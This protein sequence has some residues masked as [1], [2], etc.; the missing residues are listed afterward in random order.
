MAV[1][2]S[3]HVVVR[4]I[5]TGFDG[6]IKKAFK[7]FASQALDARKT[8][9]SLVRTGYTLGPLISQLVS[10]IGALAGGLVSLGAAA[11][12]AVPSLVSLLGVF[13]SLGLAAVVTMSAF[14]GVGA[15]IS[16]GLKASKKAATE[17]A[18]SK[19]AAARRI[20]DAEKRLA[21]VLESNTEDLLEADLRLTEAQK[22]LNKALEDGREEIQQLGFE[23]EDAALGEKKAALE[24]EKARETLAR[25][26]DLPPNSR[27]RREAQL[28][29]AEAELNLRKAKDRNADL[30]KE[31]DRLAGD[32]KKTDRYV[33]ALQAEQDALDNQTKTQRDALR[34][35]EEAEE[36]LRRAREDA[37]R[38]SGSGGLD[39][40]QEALDNL[41]PAARKFVDFIVNEFAPAL[42][43]LRDFAAAGLFPELETQLRRL[44]DELFPVLEPLFFNLAQSVGKAIKSI[45]DSILDP[46]NISDLQA[47]FDQAGY[48]VEGFGKVA[49]NVYDAFL[50][51]LVGADSQTRRFVDFLVKKTGEFA[52]F[53]D[54]K[55]ASG[56]LDAFFK[57]TGDIA[58]QW[59]A[60][61]GNTFSGIV[62]IVRANFTPGGGGYILLDWFEEATAK[63]EEF[64]GSVEGQAKLSEY[65][66]AVAIRAI[67]SSLGAFI[68]EILK[69][70]ADPNV[71]IFWDTI[72][73]AAPSFG[74]LLTQLNGAGPA[75]ANF[76]V[77]LLKFMEVTLSTGA[78]QIFWNTLNAALST[79]TNVL[80][81]PAIKKLFDAGAKIL[82]FF[83]AL[84]LI[85]GAVKFA[86]FVFGGAILQVMA[87]F[88]KLKTAILLV[89]GTF[90]ALTIIFNVGLAPLIAIAAA[91]AAVVA[92]I[93]T[94]Y[95]QSEL[96]REAVAKLI[97][98]VG[99]ALREAFETIK[100][101][102]Q[103]F[104]PEIEA[105]KGVFEKIGDFI[106]KYIV[107]LFQFVL[108]AA[109]KV[110]AE[111]VALGIRI[112]KGLWQIF[113]QS[114]LEGL[115]TIFG[116]LGKYFV[117][118]ITGIWKAARDALS[119]IPIF[120]SLMNAAERAFGVIARL[121]NATFA[122][123][124]FTV[125]DWVPAL[126]GKGFA[127]PP[128]PGF[129]EGGVIQPQPGGA[130]VRVAEAG[131]P[132]R[133]E[134]L[135][136][137][138]LSQRDKAIVAQLAGNR[139]PAN[140]INVYPSAGM[141]ETELAAM[142][143]RTLAYRLR[144]GGA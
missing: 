136:A 39:A 132:E 120:N 86:M 37:A 104:K 4:A 80:S 130:I 103:E 90:G 139:G 87:L 21:R 124:K 100:A 135:D 22:D 36:D 105:V 134:P 48:V 24:L 112:M 54:T 26:Q 9:Q 69:A 1:V 109:I 102:L 113:T 97:D 123:I 82:A 106:G 11:L 121:W 57:K 101:A 81:D 88:G 116:A 13:T 30:A 91:I 44:K 140:I 40:Y 31:Q 77:T 76:I 55:Q 60:I 10:G 142:I 35:Q 111:A 15:A 47:V 17:D 96:F 51:L 83:S 128:I 45:V 23:A 58:A 92:I 85:I 125:P 67:L 72:K 141:N 53:L 71:K 94:A 7:N 61:L 138:G 43:R 98:A 8:F 59:G 137:Q 3:A 65:F 64:S 95:T 110:F 68:K 107:P 73:T 74:S 27:A 93:I 49:G 66:K 114:P 129:A 41:S 56:E 133:I 28:A 33:N 18:A 75:F 126:G 6:D 144:R 118:G 78:I 89:K 79:L 52:K 143:D 108:V 12:G 25:V 63:F 131:R 32:P 16:A 115:K 117:N 38:K 70:G 122:K 29:F 99:T 50:S 42:K 84:G 20:E 46:E 119:G 19:I 62:N 127:I 34:R 14:S 5:T 2:G